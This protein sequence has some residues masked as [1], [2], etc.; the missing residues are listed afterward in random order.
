MLIVFYFLFSLLLL[1]LLLLSVAISEAALCRGN[2]YAVGQWVY[3]ASTQFKKSFICCAHEAAV[4][5]YNETLCGPPNPI[6]GTKSGKEYEAIS[7]R[8]SNEFYTFPASHSC[9]CDAAE[10]TWLTPSRRERYYWKP[11][12]CSL[13]SWNAKDFCKVLNNRKIVSVGDSTFRQTILTL[14]S[15]IRAGDG[16]CAHNIY[17]SASQN[18]VWLKDGWGTNLSTAFSSER[19][20]FVPDIAVIGSG[21]HVHSIEEYEKSWKSIKIQ[22]RALH[23]YLPKLKFIWKTQNT[24]HVNC[25][26]FVEPLKTA[27]K[28]VASAYKWHFHDKFD[29]ISEKNIQELLSFNEKQLKGPQKEAGSVGSGRS[30]KEIPFI[31]VMDMSPLKLRPD[32]HPR[33]M[34]ECLHYCA[35]GALDLFSV[36]MYNLLLTGQV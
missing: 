30:G 23:S 15:M 13:P 17:Y 31:Q 33:Y 2:E 4:K 18:L 11:T 14:A 5:L 26:D 25:Q 3:N 28:T 19:M 10:G 27:P 35:P 36:F 24:A 1:L 16:G 20:S 6:W 29:T 12:R 32:S 22:L 8:G 21:A 9:T 7:Y 34:K